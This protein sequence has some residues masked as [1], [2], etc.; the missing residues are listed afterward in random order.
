MVIFAHNGAL[1]CAAGALAIWPAP[2]TALARLAAFCP[3]SATQ[4]RR[5]RR[6]RVR[7]KF[8]VGL[9]LLLAVPL[10]GPAVAVS[11]G[12][13]CAAGY[14]HRRVSVRGKAE[15][16]GAKDMAE[17]IRMMVAELRR[18]APAALAAESAAAD[19]SGRAA[20]AMRTLAGTARLGADLPAGDPDARGPGHA[21]L[22]TAWSLSRRHGLPL[23]DLLDA[24]RRDILASARFA[25]RIDATM[26]GPRASAVVLATLPALGLLL[27]E[28]VG[29]APVDVLTG[30][31]AGRSLLLVG[32]LLILAGVAWSARLTRLRPPR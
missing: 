21:G 26:S 14:C 22:A 32:A 6:V 10:L 13:L 31:S 1:W 16:A 5:T 2:P 7:G 11:A 8:L 25:A 23:A 29:A 12:L 17:A 15:I 9:V 4:G 20:A 28:A 19:A 24:V 30:T 27:G 18:G 3:R